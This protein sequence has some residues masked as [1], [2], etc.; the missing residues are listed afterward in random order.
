M[1]RGELWLLARPICPG[2]QIDGHTPGEAGDERD[3]HRGGG[4]PRD[5]RS[6]SNE[7]DEYLDDDP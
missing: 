7:D 6:E 5:E 3:G 2:Q 1:R 4:A